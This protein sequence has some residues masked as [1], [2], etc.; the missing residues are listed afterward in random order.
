MFMFVISSILCVFR[1]IYPF[2][3]VYNEIT[4]FSCSFD[5][6]DFKT[7]LYKV[8]Y[9]LPFSIN[10]SHPLAHGL[11]TEGSFLNVLMA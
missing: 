6:I 8:N 2:L 5:T 3:F 10:A 4:C 9:F 11:R 7:E 1:N